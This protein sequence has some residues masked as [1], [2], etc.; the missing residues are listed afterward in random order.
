MSHPSP[1]ACATCPAHHLSNLKQA[2]GRHGRPRLRRGPGR[3]PQHRQEHGLQRAH[4]AA[5][6]HRQLAGQDRDPRR[7][8]LCDRQA[9]LQAGRSAGHL[10]AAL[11]PASTKRS[12]ATSSCSAGPTY[13]DRRRRDRPRAQP[14]P[15]AAGARDHRSRGGVP[16]PD[17]RSASAR[18]IEV[19]PRRLARDLGVPVVPTAARTGRRLHELLQAMAEVAP[20]ARPSASRT[21][22]ASVRPG[23]E[24]A[25]T[26]VSEAVL[27]ASPGLPNARWVALRLLDGDER[28]EAALRS[29]ELG[30][31]HRPDAIPCGASVATSAL[32]IRERGRRRGRSWRRAALAGRHR[33]F[34]ESLIEAL[35]TEAARIAERA[36]TRDGGERRFD[37]DRTID[38]L[39]TS[40]WLGFPMMLAMLAVRVLADD[41]R[42][43]RAVGH[44]GHAAD[45]LDRM[46]VLQ[47]GRRGDRAPW[48]LPGFV[49]DGMYLGHGLGR[50]RDAAADG[51]LLPAVHAARGFRLSAARRLQPGRLVQAARARTASRR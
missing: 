36:V 34:H 13:G 26:R 18:G 49:I 24:R 28:I 42:R 12:R 29:G 44:A 27:E 31:L 48:W 33:Q 23:C 50:Q 8:R 43:Q 41:R 22:S 1:E 20:A 6:A 11:G 5:P 10:L 25:V 4:R 7:R 19:D 37:L 16:Q 17:G 51:D 47:V 45:R 15:G 9:P 46:P 3:Q 32:P 21:A 35:Y 39:V 2:R 14:E 38:R 40:R 30:E